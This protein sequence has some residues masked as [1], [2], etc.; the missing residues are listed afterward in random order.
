MKKIKLKAW[1]TFGTSGISILLLAVV[2]LFNGYTLAKYMIEDERK[3][4]IA[5]KSFYFESDMLAP[6]SE[7]AQYTLKAGVDEISFELMNYPDELRSSDVDISYKV[8]LSR[9]G[10]EKETKEG[11]I[12]KE[13]RKAAISFSNLEAGTYVVEASATSPYT[14]TLVG[15]FTIVDTDY[16]LS[17]DVSDGANSPTLIVKVATVDYSGDVVLSW[18]EGVLPDNTDE[19]LKSAT[20]NSHTVR[21]ESQS[22]YTFRFFKTN[23]ANVY[24]NEQITAVKKQDS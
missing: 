23:P 15:K 12:T 9:D 19:L 10:T 4:P 13:G 3:D 14:K 16:E 6:A 2:L 21:M 7:T 1:R 18:P 5:A 8:T 17:Y 20:G 22:E 24:N 11:T